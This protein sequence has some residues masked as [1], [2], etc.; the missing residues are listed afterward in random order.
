MLLQC[1]IFSETCNK[2]VLRL[3]NILYFF[4][5]VIKSQLQFKYL[6]IWRESLLF[7]VAF[8]FSYF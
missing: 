8:L 5:N 3:D 4:K 1:N 7:E 2:I 6:A